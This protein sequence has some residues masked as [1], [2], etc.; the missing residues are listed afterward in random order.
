MKNLLAIPLIA[1]FCVAVVAFAQTGTRRPKVHI[2]ANHMTK[3]E[4]GEHLTGIVIDIDSL[5]LQADTADFNNAT[6]EM[7][8]HGDV[9]IPAMPPSANSK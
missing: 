3:T 6:G 1:V 7:T 8:L 4:G 5:R 9:H 2:T